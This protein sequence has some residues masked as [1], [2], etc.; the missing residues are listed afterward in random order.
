MGIPLR[1][2][3][4][5][6]TVDRVGDVDQPTRGHVVISENLAKRLFSSE[7]P[8]TKRIV[9]DLGAPFV[10]EIV[11]V[12]G[13]VHLKGQSADAPETIYF[14]QHQIAGNFDGR[15]MNIA[16]RTAADPTSLIPSVRSALN[17][18]EPTV[19]LAN[20]ATMEQLLSRSMAEPHFRT[21]LLG[22]FA[23]TALLLAA[24]GLY[25]VLAYIVTQ[26]RREIGVRI[27][28][29]ARQDEIFRSVIARGMTLVGL[30]LVIGL[31]GALATTRLIAWMLFRV[32]R[33]DPLVFVAAMGTLCAV[34]LVA[35][36]VPAWR[37]MR[38]DA[39]SALREG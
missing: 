36:T 12:A 1:T 31:A 39:V 22:A 16:V 10:A 23:V 4:P 2:G 17:A 7:S 29:G 30:G 24:I 26:R 15:V 18:L 34:G 19:P 28:L 8:L 35:G 21:W 27:A 6:G 13:D 38:V 11:G 20:V 5:L 33:T 3:R 25:G 14:S 32:D 9:V 37:A